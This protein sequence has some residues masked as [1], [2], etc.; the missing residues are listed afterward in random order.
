M[1]SSALVGKRASQKAHPSDV[2]QNA[3][4]TL[5]SLKAVQPTAA[6]DFISLKKRY[7]AHCRAY[8][9]VAA[10]SRRRELED[11]FRAKSMALLFRLRASLER[12]IISDLECCG[13]RED[14]LKAWASPSFFGVSAKQ[15]VSVRYAL[16]SCVPTKKCGAGCYSHDGRD[17]ELHHIFRGALNLF[18]GESYGGLPREKQDELFVRLAPAIRYGVTSAREDQASAE[19]QGSSRP[20]RIR[21]SHVGEMAATPLFTNRLAQEIH[22]LDDEVVCVIYTRHP[23]ARE[24]DNKLMV[25]NF[26]LEGDED[27]RSAWVPPNSRIVASAWDGNLSSVAEVN[28]LE[29][30]V[31]KVQI[32]L[33]LGNVCPVTVNHR[34][35]PSCDSARCDLCF[36]RP[37]QT[38]IAAEA[39]TNK[40]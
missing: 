7:A 5:A 1:G 20:P 22:S 15:G 3:S 23:G 19:H 11:D 18:I 40:S 38:R 35:T 12:A 25:I 39:A 36:S 32:P 26:T 14:L 8:Y 34:E 37:G 6:E 9:S 28:F 10:L 24:L 33:G 30:H 17:R 13:L 4:S 29:H 16:A 21:L 27:P 31:E 2:I